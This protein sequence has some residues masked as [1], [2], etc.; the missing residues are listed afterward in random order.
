MATACFLTLNQWHTKTNK[1]LGEVS[2]VLNSAKRQ[3]ASQFELNAPW[4]WL[5]ILSDC[6]FQ[7]RIIA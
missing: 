5:P 3:S 7:K 1:N 4:A 6:S 2:N